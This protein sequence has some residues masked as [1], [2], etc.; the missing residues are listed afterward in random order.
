MDDRVSKVEVALA[1]RTHSSDSG[2]K[3]VRD[4]RSVQIRGARAARI[5]PQVSAGIVATQHR[6]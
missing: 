2:V 6:M 1:S 3:A 5:Y 4:V